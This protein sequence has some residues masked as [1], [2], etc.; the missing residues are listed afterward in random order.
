MGRTLSGSQQEV[1]EWRPGKP[2]GAQHG[3]DLERPTVG[4]QFRVPPS[5]RLDQP[6]HLL[7]GTPPY[8]VDHGGCRGEG[9]EAGQCVVHQAVEHRPERRQCLIAAKL[10]DDVVEDHLAMKQRGGREVGV[11]GGGDHLT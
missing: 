1:A 3:L 8:T 7:M 6:Y 2:V 5:S 4:E 11:L 10:E 9:G